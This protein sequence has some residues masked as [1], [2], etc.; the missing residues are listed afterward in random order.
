MWAT[1][2]RSH[3]GPQFLL[4]RA[5]CG[6]SGNA[7]ARA[8]LPTLSDGS[9]TWGPA[10]F[11]HLLLRRGDA[12]RR[13]YEDSEVVGAGFKP[14]PTRC[15]GELAAK[16][17]NERVANPGRAGSVSADCGNRAGRSHA[18]VR[19][20]GPWAWRGVPDRSVVRCALHLA[21]PRGLASAR[22]TSAPL[23]SEPLSLW[24]DLYGWSGRHSTSATTRAGLAS[25]P[26]I[27]NGSATSKNLFVP[28]CERFVTNWIRGMPFSNRARWFATQTSPGSSFTPRQSGF[29]GKTSSATAGTPLPAIISSTSASGQGICLQHSRLFTFVSTLRAAPPASGRSE[30]PSPACGEGHRYAC[31]CVPGW[32]VPKSSTDR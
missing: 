27:F 19:V 23:P 18:V 31:H 29:S 8:A 4:P 26:L 13:P 7:A 25:P 30:N 2:T 14:A 5:Q 12:M 22:R 9:S 32:T 6:P 17:L 16:D 11:P 1:S 10:L 21:L 28:I 20:T 3:T 24:T 15:R